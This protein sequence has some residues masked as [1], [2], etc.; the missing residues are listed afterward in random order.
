M[1]IKGMTLIHHPV[2]MKIRSG[3]HEMLKIMK[4]TSTMVERRIKKRR[5]RKKGDE[6]IAS[7]SRGRKKKPQI[8]AQESDERIC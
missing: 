3:K 1:R 4:R 7:T 6:S 5:N 8:E 2:V